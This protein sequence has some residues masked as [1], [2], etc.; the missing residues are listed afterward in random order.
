MQVAGFAL[1]DKQLSGTVP[2]MPN[3]QFLNLSHK[4]FI[5]PRLDAVPATL[6]LLY[7]ADNDLTGDMLQLASHPFSGLKP[8]DLSYNNRCL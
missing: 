5:E 3:L 2:Y 8:L 1:A 6:Q 7:L 4:L